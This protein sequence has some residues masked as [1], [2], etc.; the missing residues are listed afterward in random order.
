ML[1]ECTTRW[2]SWGTLGVRKCGREGVVRLIDSFGV[3]YWLVMTANSLRSGLLVDRM[4]FSTYPSTISV[5]HSIP[6][7]TV[8][9]AQSHPTIL[10]HCLWI[11]RT[12]VFLN[13]MFVKKVNIRSNCINLKSNR[14]F[15]IKNSRRT[16]TKGYVDRLWSSLEETNMDSILLMDCLSIVRKMRFYRKRW[17][18]VTTSFLLR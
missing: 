16:R 18:R 1:R 13:L 11:K 17:N 15:T 3:R 12:V 2:S 8:Y 10:S 14:L 9:Y 6:C 7:I 5:E 4:V